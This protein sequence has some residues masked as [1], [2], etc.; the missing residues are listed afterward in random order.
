ML[1]D[2]VARRILITSYDSL[3]VN[4]AREG[5]I[6]NRDLSNVIRGAAVSQ[7]EAFKKLLLARIREIK[8]EEFEDLVGIILDGLGYEDVQVVGRSGDGGIDVVGT[9]RNGIT[10]MTLAIQ[11][12]RWRG[13]VGVGVVTKLRG[14]LFRY[15]ASQGVIITT[16]GF[17]KKA[18]EEARPPPQAGV[19]WITLIDGDLLVDLMVEHRIG[20][21]TTDIKLYDF[22]ENFFLL[23]PRKE[24]RAGE[25]PEREIP[26]ANDLN[27]VIQVAD[28]VSRGIDTP[29]TIAKALGLTARQ[30]LYYG[31]AAEIVGLISPANGNYVLTKDGESYLQDPHDEQLR[32]LVLGIP[33]FKKFLEWTKTEKKSQVAVREVGDF[34]EGTSG[35][36]HTTAQRRAQTLCSWLVRIGNA[37]RTEDGINLRLKQVRF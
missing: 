35:L 1:F 37:A 13:R 7:K 8:P 29:Q 33:V 3:P 36:S 15:G 12:K 26:Q 5:A 24:G 22:D 32:A 19:P 23:L 34:I 10:H 17:T 25:I 2:V 9:L 27:M 4:M 11:A 16:S 6:K 18:I 28:L 14:G 20:V 30:G 31:T 21:R